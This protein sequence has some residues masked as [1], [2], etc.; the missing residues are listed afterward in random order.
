MSCLQPAAVWRCY[1]YSQGAGLCCAILFFIV[2]TT[3]VQASC[4]HYVRRLGARFQPR[5]AAPWAA[6][7]E[8]DAELTNAGFILAPVPCSGPECQGAPRGQ[9]PVPVSIA[10]PNNADRWAIDTREPL[11][12]SQV[13]SWRWMESI[14]LVLS[15]GFYLLPERPPKAC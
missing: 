9:L 5:A 12:A 3:E 8:H 14:L 1:A 10:P 4:G 2:A 15:D 11:H 6:A 7:K 13:R